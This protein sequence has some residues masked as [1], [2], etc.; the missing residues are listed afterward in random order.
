MDKKTVLILLQDKDDCKPFQLYLEKDEFDVT[1]CDNC[2]QCL[3]QIDEK[4]YDAIL[5][6]N[7]LS[8]NQNGLDILKRIR[9][10]NVYITVILISNE[11]DK[12][13]AI[14]AIRNQ[15]DDFLV[16]PLDYSKLGAIIDQRINKRKLIF[17]KHNQ[18]ALPFNSV[19]NFDLFENFVILRDSMPIF[20]RGK[21]LDNENKSLEFQSDETILLS[22]FLS[23]LQS[24]SNTVFGMSMHELSFGKWKI[25]FEQQES[26]TCAI[27]V[28]NDYFKIID[29]KRIKGIIMNSLSSIVSIV[30][31]S[32]PIEEL[33]SN[34]VIILDSTIE[35]VNKKISTSNY[36]QPAH[37]E[38]KSNLK[39]DVP[40]FNKVKKKNRILSRLKNRFSNKKSN[41]NKLEV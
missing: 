25:I 23:A 34:L 11:I 5:I 9:S 6:E 38:N 36:I 40:E 22:G 26:Y 7:S 33:G 41:F 24:L 27:R 32:N 4:E 8:G 3:Q 10:E 17:A 2:E 1:I 15:S 20:M 39:H 16:K 13:I 35:T 21:W 29:Q 31:E 14:E 30:K 19:D 12:D 18:E 28:K 37:G